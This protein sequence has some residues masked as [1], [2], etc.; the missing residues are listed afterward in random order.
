MT[1]HKANDCYIVMFNG[2]ARYFETLHKAE[3]YMHK[4][5]EKFLY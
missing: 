4:I 1:L 5:E 3:E 2:E